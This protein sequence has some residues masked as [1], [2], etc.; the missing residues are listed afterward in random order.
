MKDIMLECKATGLNFKG[1]MDDNLRSEESRSDS[2]I[3][4]IDHVAN[5]LRRIAMEDS[6]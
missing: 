6:T 2:G 5:I 1:L 3:D 4:S